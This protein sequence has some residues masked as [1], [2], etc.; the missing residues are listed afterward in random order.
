MKSEK[1]SKRGKRIEIKPVD[2]MI[3]IEQPIEVAEPV[4]IEP[5]HEVILKEEE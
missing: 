3:D 2:E 1:K 5:V 4:V